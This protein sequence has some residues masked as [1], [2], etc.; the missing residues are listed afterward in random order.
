MYENILICLLGLLLISG[1]AVVM[2]LHSKSLKESVIGCM[3]MIAIH[4]IINIACC[5]GYQNYELA[6][7]CYFYAIIMI[8][9]WF[10]SFYIK[11]R[12]DEDKREKIYLNSSKGYYIFVATV[13][14]SQRYHEMARRSQ[15]IEPKRYRY[16]YEYI[17]HK[18]NKQTYSFIAQ[19]NVMKYIVIMQLI[20]GNPKT[21]RIIYREPNEATLKKFSNG[22]FVKPN[23]NI[24][25]EEELKDDLEIRAKYLGAG[26]VPPPVPPPPLPAQ[27]MKG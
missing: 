25:N 11:Y 9:I 12:V 18:G 16:W 2:I 13:T 23:C 14:H 15:M 6:K 3:V 7:Y 20:I 19:A 27:F 4:S 26:A 21:N 8:T 1:M 5:Y 10:I 17:N 24:Y 22:M